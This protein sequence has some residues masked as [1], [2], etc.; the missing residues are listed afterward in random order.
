MERLTKRIT[1]NQIELSAKANPT[2]YI[3]SSQRVHIKH[4]FWNVFNR[5]CEYEQLEEQG[6]LLKLPCKV[7]DVFWELNNANAI[8]HIYPRYAHTLSHCVYVLERLGTI[9]FLTKEEAEEKL[10]E[11]QSK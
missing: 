3:N 7:G 8:P 4:P 11:L 5:L 2:Q 1:E 10:K 9:T 6:L